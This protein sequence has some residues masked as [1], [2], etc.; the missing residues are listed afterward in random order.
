MV[1]GKADL[2]LALI[3]TGN[4]FSMLKAPVRLGRTFGPEDDQLSAPPA[5]VISY[6]FWQSR[7]GAE[8]NAI[9]KSVQINNV[10]VTIVGVLS[11]AFTGIQQAVQEAPD[12]TVPIA[13]H[14]RLAQGPAPLNQPVYWWLQV[15]GRLKPGATAAGVQ[16]NLDTVFQNSASDTLASYLGSLPPGE[17]AAARNQRRRHIPQLRVDSGSRGIYDANDAD[18]R[19][20]A[21]L[22]VVVVLML[23]MVCANVANLLLSRATMRQKEVSVRLSLG[24]TRGR[25]IRQLMTESV[26][27]AA[28]GASLGVLI[29]HWGQQLLPGRLGQPTPLDWRLLTFVLVMTGVTTIVFGAAPALRATGVAVNTALKEH[30]RS[31]IASRSLLSRAL[32]VSQVC[33]SLVLLV[34]AGLFLRT[35]QNL[36]SVDVGFNAQNLVLFRVNPQLNGY[37]EARALQFYRDLLNRISG[38]A[39]VSGAGLSN[40]ALLSGGVNSTSIFV[41]GRVHPADQPESINRLVVS[42]H[43][44]QVMQIP[45]LVGRGLTEHDNETAA[46]VVL[47]NSAAVQRHFPNVNPIGQRIGQSVE[48]AGQLEIVGVVAD[49]KYSSVRDPAPPTLYVPYTQALTPGVMF[50]V[51]T[52]G[53]PMSVVGAIRNAVRQL[54]PNLPIANVSTQMEQVEQRFAQERLFA[55]A[56]LGFGGLA[57]LLASIG[58]FGVMSYNVARRTNEIGIRMALGAQ[59]YNVMQLVMGESMTL[60]LIGAVLGLVAAVAAGRLVARQLYGIAATDVATMAVATSVLLAVALVAGYLPARRAARVDPMVALRND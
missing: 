28:I 41:Q 43:F 3:A 27:L 53:G 36:R 14:D 44:L 5:V 35:V 20:L 34:G 16:A 59:H 60:V 39:G 4:Y 58:L 11:P 48:T 55:N 24:A 51:R 52:A 22:S 57:L 49:A 18:R 25:L 42:P 31:V 15:M 10:P 50:T 19:A 30:N 9:G 26:L 2:A 29:G 37:D 33:I 56:Y 54:D 23:L 47:I 46:K 40:V 6:G 12:I 21:I 7:F 17:R 38:I 45:L 1:D 13:L 8:A 32:L